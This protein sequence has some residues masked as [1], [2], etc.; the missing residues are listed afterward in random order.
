MS[1]EKPYEPSPEEMKKVEE[2]MTEEEKEKSKEREATFDAGY[3]EHKID[4]TYGPGL[5]GK[6]D[7]GTYEETFKRVSKK[8]KYYEDLKHFCDEKK[9]IELQVRDRPSSFEKGGTFKGI[10]SDIKID[11]LNRMYV[12]LV[13]ENNREKKEKASFYLEDIEDIKFLRNS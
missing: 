9:I 7:G 3:R 1:V 13:I 6:R 4:T 12:M 8:E 10:I 2:M 5:R 11:G